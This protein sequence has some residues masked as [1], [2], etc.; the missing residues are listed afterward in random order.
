MP[1]MI[2]LTTQVLA[3]FRDAARNRG[4]PALAS[5]PRVD[6]TQDVWQIFRAA[7]RR[8]QGVRIVRARGT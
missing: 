3:E 8:A 6:T 1:Y 4:L 2:D 5:A 7:T